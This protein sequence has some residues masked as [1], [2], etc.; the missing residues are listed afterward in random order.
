VRRKKEEKG[1]G[2]KGVRSEGGKEEEK[3]RKRGGKEEEKGGKGV[4]REKKGQ[5]RFCWP[6]GKKYGVKIDPDPFRIG[7][8]RRAWKPSIS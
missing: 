2:G 8:A 4:K 3:R 5:V 1:Q 7:E 6:A